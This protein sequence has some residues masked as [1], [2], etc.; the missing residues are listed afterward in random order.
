MTQVRNG[1]WTIKTAIDF[2]TAEALPRTAAVAAELRRQRFVDDGLEDVLQLP[3][4]LWYA[5][6]S[7]SIELDS[8]R[9]MSNISKGVKRAMKAGLEGHVDKK[10]R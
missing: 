9:R 4:V 1:S 5:W 2:L 8:I 3:L 6:N 7:W 10:R